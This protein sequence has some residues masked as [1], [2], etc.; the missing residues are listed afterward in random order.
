MKVEGIWRYPVKSMAGEALSSAIV[1]LRGIPGDR[2]WAVFDEERGGVTGAKRIPKL[3]A[4]KPRYLREPIDGE[5]SPPVE[6]A[7]PNGVTVRSDDA[8]AGLSAWLG[9][10]VSLVGLDGSD[11]AAPRLTLHEESAEFVRVAMGL[12]EG[13]PEAD[14]SA[15]PPERLQALRR[16]NF[17]DALPIHLI[18]RKTLRTL[19]RI[20][21]DVVWDAR[22]FRMN[23][24]VE[25]DIAGDFP[26][27]SWVGR[28][29][30]VGG[31]VLDIDTECP[32]CSMAT[33][34]VDEVPHDPRVMRTLVREIHHS[35]GV[36]AAIHTPGT[37]RVGDGVE[38]L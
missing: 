11:V 12:V 20:A 30:R 29:V 33:Q 24:L 14:L 32:R 28:K 35:A 17:F 22:R 23:I 31:S 18:T 13:E 36:Y 16:G 4:G 1:G 3:R 6:I 15:L 7:L 21:P 27:L 19:E 5:P 37:F 34:A 9:K 2:G 10:P 8:S 26:E 25:G 38:I